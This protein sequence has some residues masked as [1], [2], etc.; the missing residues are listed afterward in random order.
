MTGGQYVWSTMSNAG[1]PAADR[2]EWF[3][4]MVAR[5]VV[6][7][8]VSS[9]QAADFKAEAAFLSLGP[10]EVSVHTHPALHSRRPAALT[11]RSDPEQYQLA[12][13]DGENPMWISQRGSE[14]GPVGGELVL[15]DTS[16]PFE[17]GTRDEQGTSRC[18]VL[19]IPRKELLIN[20]D[21]AD[22]LLARRIPAQ[23]G[24][25]AILVRF[26]TSLGEHAA[27]C[28]PEEL[29]RLGAIARDLAAVC[30]AEHADAGRE[31]D[32]GAQARALLERVKVFIEHN[33]DDPDLAPGTIAERHH[34]SVRSLHLLFQHEEESVSRLIRR[35]RLERCRADL[36]R[37]ELAHHSVRD[38]AA[39]WGFA[40]PS[41]F[42]R[43]FREAYGLTPREHRR[44][45][46]PGALAEH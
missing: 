10:V 8:A 38:L 34:I 40:N 46:V 14:S 15:W 37:P 5:D 32:A 30:L 29:G 22:R 36:A 12:L 1:V 21:K 42:G 19:H 16:R 41:A 26:L 2:F 27:E 4:D 39:R 35:R 20:P 13:V 18:L 44:Q 24:T 11:R 3:T 31:V 25:G 28:G 7:V 17:A 45:S 9:P 23:R 33:L 43:A 6:P